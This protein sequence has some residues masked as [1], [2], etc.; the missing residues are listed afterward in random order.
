MQEQ[1]FRLSGTLAAASEGGGGHLTWGIFVYS[2]IV[3]AIILVL[4]GIAR[5]GMKGRTFKNPVTLMAEQAFLFA[6]NLCVSVIGEHGRRYT[7][8]ILG[9]WLLIFVANVTGLLLPHTPTADWS[10][11]L[12]LA[13][14]VLGY[15]QWEGMSQHYAHLRAHGRDPFT[16]AIFAFFMHVRH[17]AGPNL[18]N[19]LM[20]IFIT[21]LIFA[22]E[23]ISEVIKI[24]SLSV[25]LYGNINAGHVAKHTLDDMVWGLGALIL[26]LEFLVCIIQAFVFVLL[27]CVYLAL[28]L[29]HEEEGHEHAEGGHELAHAGAH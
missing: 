19:L 28:T 10:L 27:T 9:L 24:L 1:Y 11:N 3:M 29:H 18:G 12:G 5:S 17:F 15:V 25:R 2:G 4:I 6:E 8:M 26:P 22:I 20:A 7:G 13:L 21:P 16:A 23:I 14:V